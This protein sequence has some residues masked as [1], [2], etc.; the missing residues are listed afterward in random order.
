MRK[1]CELYID[2]GT[3]F[4]D[5]LYVSLKERRARQDFGTVRNFLENEEYDSDA[6]MQDVPFDSNSD[7]PNISIMTNE[8]T[9]HLIKEYIQD[10][11]RM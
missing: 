6:I 4:I 8:S 7:I 10:Q 9:V 5:G 2:D 1:C 3:T 11:R